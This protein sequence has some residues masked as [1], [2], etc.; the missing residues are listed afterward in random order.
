VLLITATFEPANNLRPYRTCRHHP[1]R[2]GTLGKQNI[3]DPHEGRRCSEMNGLKRV[4]PRRTSKGRG[5]GMRKASPRSSRRAFWRSALRVARGSFA[6]SRRRGAS[7]D[8]F[9]QTALN[10]Q[11]IFLPLDRA[12]HGG[13][14]LDRLA[15]SRVRP[16]LDSDPLCTAVARSAAVRFNMSPTRRYHLRG[17][18]R[19]PPRRSVFEIPNASRGRSLCAAGTRHGRGP[20]YVGTPACRNNCPPAC[21][22]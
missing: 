7:D 15:F 12:Q 14:S 20:G 13:P 4:S 17:L 11:R 16:R 10:K 18:L 2:L 22:R 9:A 8:S 19:F 3:R 21:A 5:D 1:I 6:S